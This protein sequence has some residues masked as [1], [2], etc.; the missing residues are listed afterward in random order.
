MSK[1]LKG[2]IDHST[3]GAQWVNASL[4]NYGPLGQGELCGQILAQCLAS[5]H[6]GLRDCLSIDGDN[7]F[8]AR[9][10]KVG[11]KTHLDECL[12]KADPLVLKEAESLAGESVLRELLEPINTIMR[13]D[14]N[15]KIKEFQLGCLTKYLFSCLIDADRIDSADHA[16][17]YQAEERTHNQKPDWDKAIGYLENHLC[18][19]K[20]KAPIDIIRHDV[21]KRCLNRALDFQGIYTLSVPTGGGKTLS[22]L[23]YALHHAKKHGLDRIIFIIP[24]TTIIDQNA[25]DIREILESDPCE[26]GK[27]VLEH[28]SSLVPEKETWQTKLFSENWDRPVV[29]TTMVQ[30]LEA[31]FGSGTRGARHIHPMARSVLI[32]DEIQTIP[33]KCVHLFCN[34][35]NFMTKFMHTTAVLCTATQPLLDRL[36]DDIKDKGQLQLSNNAEVMGSSDQVERLFADLE[37]VKVTDRCRLGGWSLDE[38]ADFITENFYTHGSCLVIVNTK[39]WALNLYQACLDRGISQNYLFHLS[40]NQCP[41]HR[42]ALMGGKEIPGTLNYLLDKKEPVLCLSTQLIEA[43]VNISF[44]CVVRFLAGLDSIAQA[45]GRSNRHGEIRDEQGNPLKGDVYIVNPDRE[46][47]GMLVDIEVGKE[48]A[49]RILDEFS[50]ESMLSPQCMT[51]YFEYYFFGRREDMSY[52]LKLKNGVNRTILDMLSDNSSNNYAK[53]NDRRM[54]EDRKPYPLLMQS[55]QSAAQEFNAIDAPTQGI[56]VPYGKGAELIANLCALEPKSREFFVEFESAQQYSVNVFPNVFQK[57]NKQNAIHDIQHTGIMCL[58]EGFYCKEFGL[59]EHPASEFST[60][61]CV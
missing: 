12:Q 52:P 38:L 47:T 41:A 7:I 35:L 14:C 24:F 16:H 49:R 3:A 32:F 48:K 36:P 17:H 57:L 20:S 26:Q 34:T 59:S 31:W 9:M 2:K 46:S 44:G 25:Q 60:L 8:S 22:S 27:W 28:H 15:H 50:S 40:T 43:G 23:R 11:E 51:Q 56:I 21:S 1:G 42:K 33:I 6:G 58:D 39:Q 54:A 10:A 61:L 29:F 30:F 55:F 13:Q 37:R 53:K 45:A 18:T 19:L 5:H 4:K